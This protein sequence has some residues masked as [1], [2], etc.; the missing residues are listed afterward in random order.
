MPSGR[1]GKCLEQGMK[2]T[3][4]LDSLKL[5]SEA[6]LQTRGTCRNKIRSRELETQL[7]THMC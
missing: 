6:S 5:E 1:T 3:H 4:N 2:Q 7:G